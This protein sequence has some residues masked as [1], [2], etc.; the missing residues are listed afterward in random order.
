MCE[1]ADGAG[2]V[3]DT[4]PGF[5]HPLDGGDPR[6]GNQDHANGQRDQWLRHAHRSSTV[7]HRR[8][9]VKPEQLLEDPDLGPAAFE[10]L[11]EIANERLMHAGALCASQQ[12]ERESRSGHGY[13]SWTGMPRQSTVSAFF[14]ALTSR[15]P[16]VVIAK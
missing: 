10:L 5:D 12:P 13:P 16:D 2:D 8:E 1:Q 11:H 7:G 6:R 3:V 4:R 14:A 9:P 15:N